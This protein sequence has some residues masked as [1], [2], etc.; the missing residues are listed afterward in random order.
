MKEKVFVYYNQIT[1]GLQLVTSSFTS[2]K[3]T[4]QA[5]PSQKKKKTK[6]K[7]R[8][9]GRRRKGKRWKIGEEKKGW[10]EFVQKERERG[11]RDVEEKMKK[12]EK[13][14]EKRKKKKNRKWKRRC[15]KGTALSKNIP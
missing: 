14:K 13:E 12:K 8:M 11:K 6:E 9:K 10:K 7:E 15:M 1:I 2:W 3:H 5:V 4:V